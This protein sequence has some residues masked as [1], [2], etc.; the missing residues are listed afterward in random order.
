MDKM[1]KSNLRTLLP[2]LL[3]STIAYSQID[4]NSYYKNIYNKMY[5]NVAAYNIRFASYANNGAIYTPVLND[6]NPFYDPFLPDTDWK[7]QMQIEKIDWEYPIKGFELYKVFMD[8]F[9]YTQDSTGNAKRIFSVWTDKYFLIALNKQTEDIKFISGQFFINA[10]SDDFKVDKNNP[11]SFLEYLKFRIF[12]YQVKDI[13]F[14]K[15][16][17]NRYYYNAY[18]DSLMRSVKIVINLNDLEEPRVL[19]SGSK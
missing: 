18:S 16:K 4:S 8:G 10:I 15:K 17:G 12:R 7:L 2:V 5:K 19:A 3:L 14:I 11:N 6:G 9:R 1:K 13:K